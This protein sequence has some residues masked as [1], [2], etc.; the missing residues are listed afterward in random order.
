MLTII[1]IITTFI[2]A[3]YRKPHRVRYISYQEWNRKVQ[4]SVIASDWR[5]FSSAQEF[6]KIKDLIN[7]KVELYTLKH[8][9]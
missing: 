7:C 3:C 6:N 5:I 2:H 4:I 9:I 1:L 8:F